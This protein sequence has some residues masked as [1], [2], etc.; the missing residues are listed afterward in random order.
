MG[1]VRVALLGFG[2]V[3]RAFVAAATDVHIAAVADS[4]GAR[5]IEGPEELRHL[6]ALKRAGKSLRDYP[7]KD[8]P[9]EI[10]DLIGRL[11]D[12]G[13]GV[14]VESLPTNLKDGQP[15]LDWIHAAL[16]CGVSVVTVDKGP[17]VH[18]FD[19]LATAKKTGGAGLAFQGTTGVW[20]SR[21]VIGQAVVEIQG[22]LNGTTNYVL[23]EMCEAGLDFE[24]ALHG[25][26][27]RGIAEPDP[28]LDLE[29]WDAAAKILILAKML[30]NAQGGLSD[31]S[32]TGIGPATLNQV[33]EARAKGRVV[34]LLARARMSMGR[35]MLSVRPEILG[36]DSPFF[37]VSG[38][39]KAA[40]FRT[41]EGEV[42]F[43]PASSGWISISQI[44]MEDIRSITGNL[45]C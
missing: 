34:R 25:A 13:V 36:A 24:S 39:T 31:V 38:A 20:P 26:Q 42:F 23:S 22:I 3:A 11:N 1:N 37:S 8:S 44:I 32:R 16:L 33:R 14:L 19:R 40:V 9:L 15:A 12:L 7:S 4:S 18:G 10:P 45:G 27:K 43:V 21:H 17:L 35:V 30:M 6:L 28:Q 29:G 2:N 41:A 5:C